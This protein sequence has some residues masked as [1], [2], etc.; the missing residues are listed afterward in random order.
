MIFLFRT[1]HFLHLIFLLWNCQ[2]QY[3]WTRKSIFI[4]IKTRRILLKS[5]SFS[6]LIRNITTPTTQI[7]KFITSFHTRILNTK[8]PLIFSLFLTRTLGRIISLY[9]TQR[10][11][12]PYHISFLLLTLLIFLILNTILF[13]FLKLF[14]FITPYYSFF[15]PFFISLFY[16]HFWTQLFLWLRRVWRFFY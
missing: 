4:I 2:I 16:T 15:S 9:F 1:I 7:N 14:L 5:L 3:I 11:I 12:K 6:A 13:I 8:P 10:S